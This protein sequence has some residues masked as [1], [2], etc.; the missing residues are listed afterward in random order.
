[1]IT[2]Q[3]K[4]IQLHI[5]KEIDGEY[6]YLILKRSESERIYP[7]I[8]QVVTGTI[9]DGEKAIDAAKREMIEETALQFT[10][11][12]TIPYVTYYF[13]PYKD[14]ANASPVFGALVNRN[15]NVILS[16]EHSDYKWERFD[17]GF[18]LLSLPSHKQA[19][20]IFLDFC[21]NNTNQSLF[22]YKA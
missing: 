15:S 18:D 5:A 4:T 20:K 22:E 10:K 8:W 19:M 2:F 7:G 14:V 16:E 11:F 13:D 17:N 9:E 1:M 12:W 6:F 3:S 21:L